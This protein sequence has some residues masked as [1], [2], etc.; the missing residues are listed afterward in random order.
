MG[1][2]RLSPNLFED[3]ETLNT[4]IKDIKI[5]MLTTLDESGRMHS[6]PMMT[7]QTN[8]DGDLWFFT[9]VRSHKT[10]EVDWNR[11]VHLNYALPEKNKYVSITGTG[12]IVRSKQ[13]AEE[14]WNDVYRSWF[15]KGLSDP[16]LVLLRVEV[17]EAEYW[18]SDT[19]A[20]VQVKGKDQHKKMDLAG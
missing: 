20:S 19:M 11:Q 18:E 3:R 7:Q 9:S 17:D 6:R 2:E 5:A 1:D 12:E 8:F 16:D 4:L 14:L 13:K 15:P 10:L